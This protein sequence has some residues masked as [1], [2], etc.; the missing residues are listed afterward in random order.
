M[1]VLLVI[2]QG[3]KSSTAV[4]CVKKQRLCTELCALKLKHAICKKKQK[5]FSDWMLELSDGRSDATV[6]LGPSCFSVMQDP[7]KQLCANINFSTV[8]TQRKRQ[9]S[10][11]CYK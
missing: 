11:K 6:S 5:K 9:S 1:Q 10:A 3:S 7:M 8:T 2:M 4:N